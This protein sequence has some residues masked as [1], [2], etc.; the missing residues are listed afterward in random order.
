MVVKVFIGALRQKGKGPK[1]RCFALFIYLLLFWH[2]VSD[3]KYV[4]TGSKQ[5]PDE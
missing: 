3:S 1:L 2:F 4:E 5:K